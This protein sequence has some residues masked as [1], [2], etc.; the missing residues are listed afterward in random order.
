MPTL[1]TNRDGAHPGIHAWIDFVGRRDR[2]Q[3]L[4]AFSE[5]AAQRLHD[6]A[7]GIHHRST[8]EREV[9]ADVLGRESPGGNLKLRIRAEDRSDRAGLEYV[10]HALCEGVIQ[11]MEGFHV[12]G[13]ALGDD[14]GNPAGLR[15]VRGHGLLA[16]DVLS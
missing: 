12:H 2:V 15:R 8:G 5:N 3:H 13:R 7:P 10:P 9:E 4:P 11:E 16:Q 14:V 1:L 6:V